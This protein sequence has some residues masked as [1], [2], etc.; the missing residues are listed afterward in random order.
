MILA[1]GVDEECERE[2]ELESEI[3]EEREVEVP[4][5]KPVQEQCWDYSF[6]F[7]ESTPSRLPC[8]PLRLGELVSTHLS[9]SSLSNIDWP[10]SI[11]CTSNFVDTVLTRTG[12]N[13]KTLDNYLR[14]VDVIIHFPSKEIL[15]V[16][17]REAETLLRRFLEMRSMNSLPVGLWFGH[18]SFE[19]STKTSPFLRIGC[20]YDLTC[21]V[22]DHQNCAIQL[23]AGETM[24]QF[25]S[26][27]VVLKD[28]LRFKRI[29]PRSALT[30]FQASCEPDTLIKMRGKLIFLP[31]SDLEN[32]CD[33]IACE[34]ETETNETE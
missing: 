19:F 20:E 18:R 16:S 3:E 27:K 12:L 11:F 13:P 28:M 30:I 34:I 15:L 33:S 14:L 22:K 5:M 31:Y 1:N 29:M 32:I 7:T 23:F 24:Y 9:P 6:V 17:E 25:Q 26:Q 2:L 21:S 10:F 4:M 8:H